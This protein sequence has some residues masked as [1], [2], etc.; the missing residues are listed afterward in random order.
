[1]NSNFL[2]DLP[3]WDDEKMKRLSNNEGDEWKANPTREACK[4][5]YQQW[6]QVMLMLKGV[7]EMA[8]IS[9]SEYFSEEHWEAHK[10][11]ILGDGYQVATKIHSSEAGELYVL[12]ME[13]A[14]IIRKNAQFISSS[15]L[16][17]IE[18]KIIEEQYGMAVRNEIDKFR[19]LFKTWIATFTK[20]EFEDEWGLFI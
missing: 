1:M 6:Q 19:T 14:A 5:L 13:N 17:L 4:I 2:N 3:D 9:K 15:M 12:K 16:F 20:D 11:M 18:E 7:F 10:A 8:D